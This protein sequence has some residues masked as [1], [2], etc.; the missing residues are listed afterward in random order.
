MA[1][2]MVLSV[3]FG[4]AVPKHT[5]PPVSVPPHYHCDDGH[6]K[7]DVHNP[8][9]EEEDEGGDDGGDDESGSEDG[10]DDSSEE[11]DNNDEEQE[12]DESENNEEQEEENNEDESETGDEENNNEEEDS[13]DEG[14]EDEE[15]TEEE[16]STKQESSKKRSKGDSGGLT[17]RIWVLDSEGD[18]C[19][20]YHQ[21]LMIPPTTYPGEPTI[22]HF[23][24]R[25]KAVC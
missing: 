10:E 24:E 4:M 23:Y 5:G 2:L 3:G 11:E 14:S 6:G 9:C 19:S 25:T 17:K 12:E 20:F 16:V 18:G 8:H 22:I 21:A 13:S 15:N 1:V 7:D